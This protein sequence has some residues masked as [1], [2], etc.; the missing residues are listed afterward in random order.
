MLRFAFRGFPLARFN[1]AEFRR[2]VWNEA[3][4]SAAIQ[5]IFFAQPVLICKSLAATDNA[6]KKSSICAS[7]NFFRFQWC[8]A[9]I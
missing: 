2:V 7:L 9:S 1:F 4:V 3:S 6:D 5:N 8:I